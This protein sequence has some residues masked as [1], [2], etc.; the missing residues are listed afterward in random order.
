MKLK[1][2]KRLTVYLLQLLGIGLISALIITCT[3][4]SDLG[5][6]LL[7]VG[8]AITTMWHYCSINYKI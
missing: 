2:K 6:F 5:W 3:N 8:S 1:N 7:T 4:Y